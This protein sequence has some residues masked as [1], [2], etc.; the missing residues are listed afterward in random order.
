GLRPGI[1]YY[2]HLD[3]EGLLVG[4]GFHA[5]SS[6]QVDRYREAVD[7]D[8][9][10]A[11][12]AEIVGGLR[13]QGFSIEGDQLK[14]KPRGYAADH[15]RVD[16]LRYKSLMA[17]KRFGTPRWLGTPKAADRVRDAWHQ[18]SPLSSWII[19]NVGDAETSDHTT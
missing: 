15:P 5:H 2:V 8:A 11:D 4:G 14:T 6:R 10:G 9:T 3:A 19:D 12:L 17:A 18:L 7:D 1:G 13:K 16:L